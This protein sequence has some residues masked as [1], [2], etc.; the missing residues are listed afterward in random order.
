MTL[1][2]IRVLHHGGENSIGI[3]SYFMIGHRYKMNSVQPEYYS[4]CKG[5]PAVGLAPLITFGIL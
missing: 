1:L 5:A 2:S 3:K 4:V